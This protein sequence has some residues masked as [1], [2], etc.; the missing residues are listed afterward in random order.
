MPPGKGHA[1]HRHPECEEILYVLD[2]Q[3]EQW[4][5]NERRLLGPGDV[6]HIP[7]NVVH[8]SYNA[9]DRPLVFL[10]ML[11]PATGQGPEC[12]EVHD[13][14]PRRSFRRG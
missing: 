12:V 2:G 8:A 6:A 1:F 7:K 9:S 4:V 11:S 13:Q 14:E 10:A 3:A 5:D